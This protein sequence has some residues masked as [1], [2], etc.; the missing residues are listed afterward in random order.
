MGKAKN[1]KQRV[2]SHFRDKAKKEIAMSNA[3][4]NV[5][6]KETGN[7][8]VALLH[9]SS[10]IKQLYPLYNRS[11]KRKADTYGLFFYEDKQGVLHLG[12]NHLKL[13]AKPLATFYTKFEARRFIE[14]LCEEFELCPKYCQLSSGVGRCFHHQIKKCNGVCCNNEA[15][16]IY[17]QRVTKALDSLK[18]FQE[19]LIIEG[20]GRNNREKS[21]VLIRQG[22]YKGY[23]FVGKR[24]KIE[25]ETEVE[26]L[27]NPQNNNRDV[28][29]ILRQ[30]FKESN[31]V[32]MA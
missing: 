29:R 30:Y 5:T 28:Q 11:Q 4:A 12:Y 32:T 14:E 2:L 16:T 3:T 22:I 7:E 1:I 19:D 10:E 15:I 27:I 23:G 26:K 18:G 6:F 24:K 9:E 31:S 13:I 20:A 17:N 8:L 25:L 21:I